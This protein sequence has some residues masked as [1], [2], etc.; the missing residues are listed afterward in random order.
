M[1]RE[2]QR[3]QIGETLVESLVAIAILSVVAVAAYAG[4]RTSV[5]SSALHRESAEAETILRTAAERLQDP[6]TAYIDRA[7]CPGSTTYGNLPARPGYVLTPTVG[8]WVPPAVTVR[9]AFSNLSGPC[10]ATPRADPGLQ[11][12]RLSVTTPSGYVET[13][14]VLKRR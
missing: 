5:S 7:G 13:L 1:V 2:H 12:I 11:R 6:R 3:S 14:D 9:D 10:P 4:L 8:F